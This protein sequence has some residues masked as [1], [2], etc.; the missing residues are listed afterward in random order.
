MGR[1]KGKDTKKTWDWVGRVTGVEAGNFLRWVGES[2]M[3]PAVEMVNSTDTS[4]NGF[5]P[6]P[7]FRSRPASRV[8]VHYTAVT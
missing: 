5:S 4:L 1:R 3:A 2:R 7:F 6:K 8:T